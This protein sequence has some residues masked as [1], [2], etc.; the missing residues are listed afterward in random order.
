MS[1]QLSLPNIAQSDR[2][3]PATSS[4]DPARIR[5]HSR[6]LD[7]FFAVRRLC[8]N[9]RGYCWASNKAL[10]KQ[11]G[12]SEDTIARVVARL[13]A[14]GAI[15]VEHVVGVE[16]RLRVLLAPERLKAMLF[17]GHESNKR[18]FF[19]PSNAGSDAAPVAGGHKRERTTFS[20]ADLPEGKRTTNDSVV[21]SSPTAIVRDDEALAAVEALG[22][23]KPVAVKIANLAPAGRVKHACKAVREYLSKSAGDP[24]KLAYTA[25]RE[26]WNPSL[27]AASSP[28]DRRE[29]PVRVFA[30]PAPEKIDYVRAPERPAP[31]SASGLAAIELSNVPD[32][33]RA[34]LLSRAKGTS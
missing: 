28:S 10:G 18:T 19:S 22:V 6:L 15:A 23:P 8:R 20:P 11:L 2:V 34:K 33:L 31:A 17:R 3:P 7:L 21:V 5:N 29:R 9:R 32:S 16:R 13:Q 26:G 12:C 1:P 14:L 25:V 30:A 24:I 4:T 27:P